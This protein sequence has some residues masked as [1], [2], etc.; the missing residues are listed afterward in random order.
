M[1]D[2][3]IA[4]EVID[5]AMLRGADF[6]EIFIDRQ[7]FESISIKSSKVDNIENGINFGIG[8]RLFYGTKVLYGYTNSKKKI[9]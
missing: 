1:L 6:A 5:Y 8:I 3:Q 2:N 7:T 4:K 9:F